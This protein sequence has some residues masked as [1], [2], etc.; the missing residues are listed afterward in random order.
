M[1]NYKNNE[2]TVNQK[3]NLNTKSSASSYIVVDTK[4]DKNNC[5][6]KELSVD[7]K[8]KYLNTKSSDLAS[9]YT[10]NHKIDEHQAYDDSLLIA[11]YANKI[12]EI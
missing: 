12:D 4:I 3:A 9:K 11:L 1:N 10:S 5:K 6:N 8:A 2:R 7:Q